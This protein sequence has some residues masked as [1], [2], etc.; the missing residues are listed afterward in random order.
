LSTKKSNSFINSLINDVGDVG[1]IN[2]SNSD[3]KDITKMNK[4]IYGR[5]SIPWCGTYIGQRAKENNIAPN[6]YSARAIDYAN[7]ESYTIKQVLS[8]NVDLE[9]GWFAIKDR[10]G[11]NHVSVILKYDK[12]NR[13]IDVISGNCGDSVRIQRNVKLSLTNRFGYTRFTKTYSNN[14]DLRL[15]DFQIGIAS[16]YSDK[17][18]G[19]KTANGEIFSQSKLTVASNKY[20]FGTKLIVFNPENKKS[21]IVRVNDKGGFDKYDRI[22]DMSKASADS[23]G[24]LNKG[25][26][27]VFIQ[28]IR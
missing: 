27:K 28:E 9:E 15:K 6:P 18:E 19:M 7:S 11:G 2:S 23:I 24:I 20:K 17:Y 12:E 5:D 10:V 3:N 22:I 8:G 26:A 21:V 13:T 25:I 4:N 1:E 14:K 16:Y